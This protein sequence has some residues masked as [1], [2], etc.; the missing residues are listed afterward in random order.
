MRGCFLIVW[1]GACGGGST[2][3]GKPAAVPPSADEEKA[4]I[5]RVQS[6][7]KEYGTGLHNRLAA[8]EPGAN[9]VAALTSYTT[10]ARTLNAVDKANT[11][12]TLGWTSL[13]LRDPKNAAP[14]WVAAWLTS[15]GQSPESS[16]AP[17][18]R[19][20]Q[21][22]SGPMARV[23]VPIAEEASCLACHGAPDS[24][25]PDLKAALASAW[26]EDKATGFAVGDLAGA[27]WGEGPIKVGKVAGLR[28]IKPGG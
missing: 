19:I 21:T 16:A 18:G 9:P 25:S 15:Q 23:I 14:D 13:R 27:V 11:G 26:P 4:A 24:F 5:T 3:D 6:A 17:V 12:E 2:K 1:L 7:V 22:P 20:D 8:I 10:A 28:V